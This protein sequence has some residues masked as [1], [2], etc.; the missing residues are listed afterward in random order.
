MRQR[1]IFGY[2]KSG[3]LKASSRKMTD[4]RIAKM[5]KIGF[6]WSMQGVKRKRD[7]EDDESD[8]EASDTG[9]HV[10]PEVGHYDPNRQVQVGAPMTLGN[11]QYHDGNFSRY[12]YS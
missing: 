12:T 7:E 8:S 4:E 5:E 11:Y 3:K 2:K 10:Q 9:G 6:H 1:L